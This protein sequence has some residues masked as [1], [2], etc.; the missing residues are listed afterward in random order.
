MLDSIGLASPT[1]W[2]TAERWVVGPFFAVACL[3]GSFDQSEEA[4]VVDVVS[5]DLH[6]GV[7]VDIVVRP[8]TLIPLSTTHRSTTWQ[9]SRSPTPAIRSSVAVLYCSRLVRALTAWAISLSPTATPWSCGFPRPPRIWSRHHPS[10]L[11]SLNL[12]RMP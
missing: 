2:A 1:L 5:E 7:V 3:Q 6:Q 10:L 8:N 11:P 12:P 4:I 9:K